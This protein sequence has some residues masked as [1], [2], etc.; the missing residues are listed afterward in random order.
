MAASKFERDKFRELLIYVSH[1]CRDDDGFGDTHLNKV[2]YF[3]DAFALKHL[4]RAITNARYQKLPMGPAPRAL[5]PIRDE[6]IE[7]GLLAVATVGYNTTKTTALREP[8]TSMFGPDELEL[9]D[10]II[11]LLKPKSATIVSEES[12]LNSPGWNL[13]ELKEDIP[14]ETQFIS[15]EPAPVAVLERGRALAERY[16]W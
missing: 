6:M 7:E 5:L 13:V 4:G 8:D 2:L 16:G 9:V 3:S 11:E 12:H 15:T 14:L 10:S 1:Q